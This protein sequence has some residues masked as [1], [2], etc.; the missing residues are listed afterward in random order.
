MADLPAPDAAICPP[1]PNI[2]LM[3]YERV[4][5][6]MGKAVPGITAEQ[7]Q[8]FIAVVRSGRCS[9]TEI[10]KI[11]GFTRQATSRHVAKL[12]LAGLLVQR[13]DPESGRRRV[14]RLTALGRLIPATLAKFAGT[15]AMSG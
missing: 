14:V 10:C 11:T 15:A 3:G 6:E 1:A 4:T 7:I 13:R 5:T 9:Q 2:G 12:V 8:T